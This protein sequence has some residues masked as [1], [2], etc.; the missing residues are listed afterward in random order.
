MLE[1][2]LLCVVASLN[3]LLYKYP[4][5]TAEESRITQGM[6]VNNVEK[7]RTF[8]KFF[9]S[10]LKKAEA[11]FYIHARNFIPIFIYVSYCDYALV[12]KRDEQVSK[13][14][15]ITPYGRYK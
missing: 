3:N 9:L 2:A 10:K 8:I 12:S 15:M 6:L 7:S 14:S 5:T 1:R 11:P 4:T 13:L